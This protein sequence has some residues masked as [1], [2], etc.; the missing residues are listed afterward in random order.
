[1][2]SLESSRFDTVLK[3]TSLQ[4]TTVRMILLKGSRSRLNT[5]GGTLVPLIQWHRKKAQEG[6]ITRLIG[7]EDVEDMWETV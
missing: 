5:R 7:L 2:S 1:M 6:Q 4:L 3:E